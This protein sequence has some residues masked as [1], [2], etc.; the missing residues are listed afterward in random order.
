M[1]RVAFSS[2]SCASRTLSV[3]FS[4]SSASSTDSPDFSQLLVFLIQ[5]LISLI[6]SFCSILSSAFVCIFLKDLLY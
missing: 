1:H 5:V 3:I 6:D 2:T 4:D